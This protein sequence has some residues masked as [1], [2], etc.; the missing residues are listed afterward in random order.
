VDACAQQV[1]NSTIT[2]QLPHS[3]L[4]L[5]PAGIIIRG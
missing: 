2:A 4:E 3:F 1:A 5:G